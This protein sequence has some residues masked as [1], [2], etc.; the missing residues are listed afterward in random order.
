MEIDST[1]AHTQCFNI[2][3]VN[4]MVPDTIRKF[5][6]GASSSSHRLSVTTSSIVILDDGKCMVAPLIL[7]YLVKILQYFLT[8]VCIEIG[9][10]CTFKLLNSSVSEEEDRIEVVGEIGDILTFANIS[11][12]LTS[13]STFLESTLSVGEDIA[14]GT[15]ETDPQPLMKI[16]YTALAEGFEIEATEEGYGNFVEAVNQVTE[17]KK[18]ACEGGSI[19]A[20]DV[21]RLA[22]E[23]SIFKDNVIENII[24]L[25]DVFGK[26]LCI[27]EKETHER[28]RRKRYSHC[29]DRSECVCPKGADGTI[30]WDEI[31]CVC[32]FFACMD[33]EQDLKPM[34]G[35]Y[36]TKDG[37]PCLVLV[38]DTTG[39]MA[40]E[41]EAAKEVI[42]NFLRSEEDKP[43]CY[44]LLPFNDL[45]N[46]KFVEESKLWV[47]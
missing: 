40:D 20:T 3:I 2:S 28:K 8:C 23:Y 19:N 26:M 46:D 44:A 27:K 31:V 43:A 16:I 42:H 29:P 33:P 30:F 12:F 22:R 4:N 39:S 35:M 5:K 1:T 17:A 18:A 25:R 14:N 9:R 15:N 11:T 13:V 34:L 38:V 36:D 10:G 7:I 21:P 6:L 24:Q 45:S 37:P 47:C 41:I 32:E